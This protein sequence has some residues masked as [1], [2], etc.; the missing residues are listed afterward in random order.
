MFD[1]IV[2]HFPFKYK[3]GFTNLPPEEYPVMLRLAEQY[4]IR[5]EARVHQ[6]KLLDAVS[7]LNVIRNRSGLPN[8]AATTQEQILEAILQE[9]RNELFTEEGIGGLT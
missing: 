6:G 1:S 9:R 4:L 2:Y 3:L 5:A 7:D 8:T